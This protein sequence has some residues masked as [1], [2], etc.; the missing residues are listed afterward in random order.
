MWDN[1]SVALEITWSGEHKDFIRTV[2]D[3]GKNTHMQR[4]EK[5]ALG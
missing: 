3:Q 2:D 1:G 5:G 4:F